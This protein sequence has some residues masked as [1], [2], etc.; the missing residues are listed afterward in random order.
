MQISAEDAKQRNKIPLHVAS[1]TSPRKGGT[2]FTVLAIKYATNNYGEGERGAEREAQE[3]RRKKNK[4]KSWDVGNETHEFRVRRFYRH[5]AC[6]LAKILFAH[7]S[8]RDTRYLRSCLHLLYFLSFID[9]WIK[10][11]LD[12]YER[13]NKLYHLIKGNSRR[14]IRKKVEGRGKRAAKQSEMAS[15]GRDM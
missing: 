7:L 8:P 3:E 6:P 4:C 9:P 2:L 1:W 11:E 14:K 10:T 13:Q 12:S 15:V 5:L